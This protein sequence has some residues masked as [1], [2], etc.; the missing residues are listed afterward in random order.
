[1][2]GPNLRQPW[3]SLLMAC[4][5]LTG[6][7]CESEQEPEVT[8]GR[9]IRL[10]DRLSQA[11]LAGA[12]ASRVRAEFFPHEGSK[13]EAI[14]LP[15]GSTVIFDEIFI[16][17]S[18][19][20]VAALEP[21][22]VAPAEDARFRISFRQQGEW[23]LLAET[24]ADV[25]ADIEARI[26]L[27]A[28]ATT[29]LKLELT[30]SHGEVR[31]FEPKLRSNGR[32]VQGFASELPAVRPVLDL[33]TG[34][35]TLRSEGR[36]TIRS[37][38]EER[39]I[40]SE[41][42]PNAEPDA[43]H[44]LLT[45]PDLDRP[46]ELEARLEMPSNSLLEVTVHQDF[47]SP[48][49]L[50][51]LTEE[52]RLALEGGVRFSV[53]AGDELLWQHDLVRGPSLDAIRARRSIDLSAL[54]G[55]VTLTLRAEYL[56]GTQQPSREV[57]WER[58]QLVARQPQP[59]QLTRADAANVVL[60]MV[61]T[62][63]PDHLK[64]YGYDRQTSPNLDRFTAQGVRYE[65]AIS[66]S[67]WTLPAIATLFTGLSSP[68]AHGVFD[69]E[70]A[71]LAS[72]LPTLAEILTARDVL[73][74]AFVANPIVS[75][76]TNYHQGFDRF[77][78]PGD[79]AVEITDGFLSWLEAY[80]GHRFFAYLHYYDPHNPY[81]APG[82][83]QEKFCD[84]EYDGFLKQ[85]DEPVNL[86]RDQAW[87]ALQADP[88][89]FGPKMRD[90]SAN[91]KERDREYLKARYD[92]E[93]AYWDEHFQRVLDG[94]EQHGIDDRTWVIVVGDHG[95]EFFEHDGLGHG[96]TLHSEL[97]HVPLIIRGP[98]LDPQVIASPVS[99]SGVFF[100]IASLFNTP[101]E[102][103]MG[104]GPLPG[105]G[106]P[107]SPSSRIFT[108]VGKGQ[109]VLDPMFAV[110]DERWKLITRPATGTSKLYRWKDDPDEASDISRHELGQVNRLD[111]LIQTWR[112]RSEEIQPT[113]LTA[114]DPAILA[115]M[116]KMGY[117]GASKPK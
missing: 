94:L 51:A 19:R 95:D 112:A 60:V 106:L 6:F 102:G 66:S 27:P 79:N 93:I 85:V 12:G 108:A 31:C 29:S 20:L 115:E 2:T 109:L 59:R 23:R 54:T 111:K 53:H 65:Q 71:T 34:L 75:V 37:Q 52:Q 30:G 84:A 28:G 64:S 24:P 13:R 26:A 15:A 88:E 36:V 33:V 91:F 17:P 86:F 72:E 61:D 22:T 103:P 74:G 63:R 25:P 92:G 81:D 62:L 44:V 4:L 97:T 55:E 43:R 10:G 96:H 49:E 78:E 3:L 21:G 104:E 38:S 50:L 73:T 8:L 7:G 41:P 5:L 45:A 113:D 101:L 18:C 82:D 105:V 58:V 1:M 98:G 40:R 42:P 48:E 68:I 114:T 99:I 46:A 47:G 80:S 83:Y 107:T 77:E 16:N 11:R 70:R 116:K 9:V 57:S 69:H 67:S 39:P 90:L 56:P 76:K 35:D 14:V 32:L 110:R 100:T 87:R 89:G 117:I